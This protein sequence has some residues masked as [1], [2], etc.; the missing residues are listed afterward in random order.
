MLLCRPSWSVVG[1]PVRRSSSHHLLPN[2]ASASRAP[3]TVSLS[4][5]PHSRGGVPLLMSSTALETGSTEDPTRIEVPATARPAGFRSSLMS[6]TVSCT[7][8]PRVCWTLSLHISDGAAVETGFPE[9]TTSMLPTASSCSCSQLLSSI[10]DVRVAP[11]RQNWLHVFMP[12]ILYFFFSTSPLAF[13]H[14]E[15]FPLDRRSL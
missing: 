7:Y 15:A 4:H 6:T 11:C 10:R 9:W 2:L 1:R 8:L 13:N 3:V 14:N 5:S 12:P